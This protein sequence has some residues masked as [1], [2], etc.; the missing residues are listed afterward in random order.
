MS[1]SH[2]NRPV[3]PPTG[4]ESHDAK[5][6]DDYR[7]G[8]MEA[9]GT[10]VPRMNIVLLFGTV[11]ALAAAVPLTFAPWI[12][13]ERED[14]TFGQVNG[15]RGDGLVLVVASLV[16]IVMLLIASRQEPGH[17][18]RQALVGFGAAVLGAIAVLYTLMAPEFITIDEPRAP[19]SH[20][21]AW[22]LYLASL[23]AVLGAIGAS[24]LWKTA[25]HFQTATLD[26]VDSRSSSRFWRL[27][28][29]QTSSPT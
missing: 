28:V 1:Q 29:A 24:R 19:I 20:A 3:R 10:P 14:G 17:G 4:Q 8:L 11:I 22:G 16:A 15:I 9:A 21:R 27:G 5:A 13:Y 26:V 12:D 18:D 25:D 6:F 23:C 7:A 2:I